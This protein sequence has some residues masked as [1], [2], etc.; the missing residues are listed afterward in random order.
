MTDLSFR[1]ITILGEEPELL[2]RQILVV[3]VEQVT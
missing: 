2:T 3:L 1:G